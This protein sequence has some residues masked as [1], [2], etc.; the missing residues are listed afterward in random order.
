MCDYEIEQ[1]LIKDIEWIA[2]TKEVVNER[3]VRQEKYDQER[4]ER[5][6]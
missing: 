4:K 3:S 2:K 6:E 1:A 5:N